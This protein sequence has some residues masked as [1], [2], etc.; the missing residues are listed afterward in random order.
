MLTA[1][2]GIY[3]E[4]QP[5]LQLTHVFTQNTVT[6]T[7][8]RGIYREEWP[9]LQTK[10]VFTEKSVIKIHSSKRKQEKTMKY[11]NRIGKQWWKARNYKHDSLVT[12]VLSVYLWLLQYLFTWQ[13]PPQVNTCCNKTWLKYNRT[14]ITVVLTKA[15]YIFNWNSISEWVYRQNMRMAV[16]SK[17][18]WQVII[19]ILYFQQSKRMWKGHTWLKGRGLLLQGCRLVACLLHTA[20]CMTSRDHRQCCRRTRDRGH[21]CNRRCCHSWCL[22]LA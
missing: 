9:Y 17:T 10:H 6:L 7:A 12:Q 1:H 8:Q 21:C 4:H 5:Y 22:L 15:I 3:T 18:L 14:K 2:T 16:N 13:W 11:Q 19:T 20:H